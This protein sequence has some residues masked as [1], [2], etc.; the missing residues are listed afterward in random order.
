[1]TQHVQV[2][3]T[4]DQHQYK[5]PCAIKMWKNQ[6]I[7]LSVMPMM[8]IEMFRLEATPDTVTVVDKFNRRYC[9]LGYDE[10][11]DLA[12]RKISF[13][14]LQLLAKQTNKEIQFNFQ[15][16]GHNLVIVGELSEQE[17]NTLKPEPQFINKTRYKQVSLRN[18]LPI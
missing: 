9:T 5:V 11:S 17:F 7:V 15:T 2:H 18:I 10:I 6:L 1:M 16:A 3:L 14:L 4:L 13:K 8:G 12:Q